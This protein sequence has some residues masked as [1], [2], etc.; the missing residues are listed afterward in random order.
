MTT[1]VKM[2]GGGRVDS[3]FTEI[4]FP[5]TVTSYDQHIY[6]LRRQGKFLC[7]LFVAHK[8]CWSTEPR[9]SQSIEVDIENESIHSIS[10]ADCY[11]LISVID[12]N[13]THRKNY[14]FLSIGK[15]DNNR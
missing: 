4:L 5:I 3:K 13:R 1:Y 8:Y 2:G 7:S 6:L 11:R 14:R 9:R 15:I 12:N 10:I